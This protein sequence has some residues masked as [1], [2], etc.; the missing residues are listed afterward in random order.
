MNNILKIENLSIRFNDNFVVKDFN[1]ELKQGSSHALIGESGSGKSISCLSVLDLLPINAIKESG[2]IFFLEEDISLKL[3]TYRGKQIAYIP[4]NPSSSL[5]PLMK[6]GEQ[7]IEIIKLHNPN[8]NKKEIEEICGSLLFDA[9]LSKNKEIMSLYPFELSGGMCQ[10]VLIAMALAQNPCILLADEPTTGLD[11]I[12]QSEI[13]SLI[14]SL[15]ANK[16]MSLL[17]I[18][19]DLPLAF[20]SCQYMTVM[21]KGLICESGLTKNIM[22]NPSHPYTIEFIENAKALNY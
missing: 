11:V 22:L 19:H 3:K 16:K 6:I 21:K 2:E 1:L 20:Q 13:M 7:F 18:T 14:L 10:R 4:Q 9:Q 15:I 17:L 12:T 8:A 5:N